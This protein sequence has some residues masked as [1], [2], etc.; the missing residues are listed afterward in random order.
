MK[1]SLSILVIILVVYCSGQSVNDDIIIEYNRDEENRPIIV[2]PFNKKDDIKFI[3]MP[4]VI[5]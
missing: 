4:M 5:D 3:I 1:L 2:R